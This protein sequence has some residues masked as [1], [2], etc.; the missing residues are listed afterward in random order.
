L[1]AISKKSR[2]NITHVKNIAGK[3]KDAGDGLIIVIISVTIVWVVQTERIVK[4]MLN[5][6]L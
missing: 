5:S 6:N 4:E 3:Y 2:A 1:T